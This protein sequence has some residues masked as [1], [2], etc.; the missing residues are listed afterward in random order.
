VHGDLYAAAGT[1]SIADRDK[2]LIDFACGLTWIGREA[3][4]SQDFFR[5]NQCVL[6]AVV[7]GGRCQAVADL[8]YRAVDSKSRKISKAYDGWE[9]GLTR[10]REGGN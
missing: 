9:H 7:C 3:I 2:R 10:V 8:E 6:V 5:R 4:F 1:E